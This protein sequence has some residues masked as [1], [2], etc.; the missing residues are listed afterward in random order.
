LL[1][2]ERGVLLPAW[3]ELLQ[4]PMQPAAVGLLLTVP[5]P[6]HHAQ[7]VLPCAAEW[8]CLSC[9]VQNHAAETAQC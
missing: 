9:C 8:P 3:L 5:S 2:P 7:C 6:H 1:S 4:H